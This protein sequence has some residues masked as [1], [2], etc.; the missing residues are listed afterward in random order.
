MTLQSGEEISLYGDSHALI[1]GS[2]NYK[3]GWDPLP[4]VS[5]DI[6]EIKK[7]LEKHSFS[8]TVVMDPTRDELLLAFDRFRKAYGKKEN[9]R[10]VIYY[11]GHGHSLIDPILGESGYIVP[12]DA[13]LPSSDLDGFLDSA[14]DMEEIKS[15][16]KRI[17]SKHAYFVF[18]SCFAGTIFRSRAASTPGHITDMIAHPVRQFQTAGDANEAVP[19]V[20]VFRRYFVRAL[21][22]AADI[23]GDGYILASEIDNYLKRFV[24]GDTNGLQHP[25]GGKMMDPRFNEGDIVFA[26]P[27]VQPIT[28]NKGLLNSIENT[29]TNTEATVTLQVHQSVE[30]A[31]RHYQ[32]GISA[33]LGRNGHYDMALASRSFTR[34]AE[35][36]HQRSTAILAS[37]YYSGADGGGVD[38]D[39]AWQTLAAPFKSGDLY[40]KFLKAK[41]QQRGIPIAGGVEALDLGV[42]NLKKIIKALKVEAEK[43]DTLLAY[44]LA[45]SFGVLKNDNESV[46]WFK[47]SANEGSLLAINNLGI[48]YINGMGVKKDPVKGVSLLKQA[49]VAG[50]AVAMRNLGWKYYHGNGIAKNY[51]ET[52]YW[53]TQAI[54]AGDSLAISFLGAMYSTGNGVEK[55]DY[56]AVKLFIKAAHLGDGYGM[57]NLAMNLHRGLGIEIDLPEAFRWN[58]NASKLGDMRAMFN[59]ALAYSNGWGVSVDHVEAANWYE[60]A[61]QRGH[62]SA[63]FNLGNSLFN[64]RGIDKNKEKGIDW[65]RKAA[66]LGL[67]LAIKHLPAYERKL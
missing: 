41:M 10:L 52:L 55:D 63:M 53:L 54:N 58:K 20:S 65:I 6:E 39:K 31:Q 62:L 56:Q 19:D 12:I 32:Q 29:N 1:I 44:A 66:K 51:K 16:A 33:L 21:Q 34:A 61:A 22:G 23:D 60:E 49:A 43:G 24:I 26:S 48:A 42:A 37:M 11:A 9:A 14:I 38:Y 67:P 59:L 7:V 50:N 47:K 8:T 4:G 35:A 27:R 18:D 30:K 5:T 3:N 46:A 25:R 40:A 57:T 64:G 13:P 28:S 15:L 17:R 45:Y 2:S 36:G